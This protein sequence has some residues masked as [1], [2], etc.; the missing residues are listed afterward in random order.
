M[1][2]YTDCR[3]CGEQFEIYQRGR[4]TLRGYGV[5]YPFGDKEEGDWSSLHPACAYDMGLPVCAMCG[6]VDFAVQCCD[7][8][9]QEGK[10][11]AK[12]HERGL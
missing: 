6:G 11:A 10:E 4:W 7:G 1:N 2:P 8:C 9:Y 3:W 5:E 12:L